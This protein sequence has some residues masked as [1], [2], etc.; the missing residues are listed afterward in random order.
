MIVV[1]MTACLASIDE[2]RVREKP[3]GGLDGAV[4]DAGADSAPVES[5][6]SKVMPRP[7]FCRDFDAPGAFDEGFTINGKSK[8][9]TDSAAAKSPPNS[10]FAESSGPIAFIEGSFDAPKKELHLAFDFLLQEG[11]MGGASGG[12]GA[13]IAR[14]EFSLGTTA[15][16]SIRI[17]AADGLAY[18]EEWAKDGNGGTLF[19]AADFARGAPLLGQWVHLELDIAISTTPRIVVKSG[20]GVA[21]T[22]PGAGTWRGDPPRLA[23]GLA[24]VPPSGAAT[25]AARFDNVVF[26][27]R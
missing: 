26:D 6:C 19:A 2:S 9:G 22:L 15:S 12:K 25:W 5:F 7:T 1:G 4:A 20:E 27:V 16:H 24:Y 14:I 3:V 11:P 21:A 10:L 23:L 13:I 8:V 17:L 18:V